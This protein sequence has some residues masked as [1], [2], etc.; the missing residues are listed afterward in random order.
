[1]FTVS[2]LLPFVLF[3]ILS[4]DD[5]SH[6]I[7]NVAKGVYIL[8]VCTKNFTLIVLINCIFS[9]FEHRKANAPYFMKLLTRGNSQRQF[10]C[11]PRQGSVFSKRSNPLVCV[12]MCVCIERE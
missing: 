6:C 4:I 2:V 11:S 3:L 7:P 8:L 5:I 9:I 12:C 10:R 1:M